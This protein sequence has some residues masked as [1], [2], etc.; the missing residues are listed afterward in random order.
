MCRMSDPPATMPQACRLTLVHRL[1]S[2]AL[3]T[4]FC[5]GPRLLQPLRAC[6]GTDL[7]RGVG[8]VGTGPGNIY[9]SAGQVNSCFFA[10]FQCL[11]QTI[12]DLITM[13]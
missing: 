7:N 13:A 3:L 9:F 8:L 10:L 1:F 12:N 5:G 6:A 11:F 2:Q 4:V